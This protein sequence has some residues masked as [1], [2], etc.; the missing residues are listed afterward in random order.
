MEEGCAF[1][2]CFKKELNKCAKKPPKEAPGC[3]DHLHNW[4]RWLDE[5][6]KINQSLSRRLNCPKG[7]LLMN[8]IEEKRKIIEEK[9]LFVNERNYA[10]NDKYRGNPEWF[11]LPPR[12][13]QYCRNEPI[14]EIVRTQEEMREIV[15][16]V[17]IET[18]T[19]ILKEKDILPRTRNL[20]LRWQK[21]SYRQQVFQRI[22]KKMR[23]L[24]PH[25]PKLSELMVT[26]TSIGGNKEAKQGGCLPVCPKDSCTKRQECRVNTVVSKHE[27]HVTEVCHNCLEMTTAIHSIPM[28]GL[29]ING[30]AVTLASKK[31]S[32]KLIFLFQ[33]DVIPL[34]PME[35]LV[36]LENMGSTTLR[37]HF[38]KKKKFPIFGDIIPYRR[39]SS[40]FFFN[41]NEIILLPFQTIQLPIWFKTPKI[42]NFNETWNVS[43]LPEC[44]NHP[45]YFFLQGIVQI[46]EN[47]QKEQQ[48]KSMI[49]ARTR[50]T[51]VNEMIMNLI[52]DTKSEQQP[53]LTY[54][55]T[56]KDLF[57]SIN[58]EKWGVVTRPKY[59]YVKDVVNKLKELYE[60]VKKAD[61][62][63]V[64]DL[65][66]QTLKEIV[67]KRDVS[68]Y[69]ESLYKDCKKMKERAEY[70]KDLYDNPLTEFKI[71]KSS[72][73]MLQMS[74]HS[75]IDTIKSNE[76]LVAYENYQ[77]FTKLV[78]QLTRT[79]MIPNKDRQKYAMVYFIWRF[80]M[81]KIA[82][83]LGGYNRNF[84]DIVTSVNY[85]EIQDVENLPERLIFE[86]FD[87]IWTKRMRVERFKTD[88]SR[89]GNSDKRKPPCL[90]GISFDNVE[91]IHQTYMARRL[92][93]DT[94]KKK[95]NKD[96]AVTK[97]KLNLHKINSTPV[98]EYNP[99]IEIPMPPSP[100][101]KKP[102]PNESAGKVPN[103]SS[104]SSLHSTNK[105]Y[106]ERYLIVYT[107]LCMAV[108][109]MINSLET[110]A[111]KNIPIPTLGELASCK[112]VSIETVYKA[113]SG[114]K[115]SLT[116]KESDYYKY[117]TKTYMENPKT[118]EFF[119]KGKTLPVYEKLQEFFQ[120][121]TSLVSG[122]AS[123]EY[124]VGEVKQDDYA[125]VAVQTIDTREELDPI[126]NVLLRVESDEI[127]RD[128][129][130]ERMMHH[131]YGDADKDEE[132]FYIV[133]SNERTPEEESVQDDS[134]KSLW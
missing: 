90:D 106:Q 35:K 49:E 85:Y 102:E 113:Q 55:Y 89:I 105:D 67:R 111:E 88:F 2:S 133:D 37:I 33:S 119:V 3:K 31:E 12:L 27:P 121:N 94:K 79:M 5:R 43:T 54:Y 41:K 100:F 34:V 68:N 95:E 81:A 9:T 124:L 115:L 20:L 6:R 63:P 22:R 117:L 53:T 87:N 66:L 107:N 71:S 32:L 29:K 126:S 134:K 14:I 127:R 16:I 78:H 96:E 19:D 84:A 82:K 70:L 40:P 23:F 61:D 132:V 76:R 38:K 83:D 75:N 86:R 1:C 25:R 129:S 36:V 46:R 112:F 24:E 30:N 62:P 47:I 59:F 15:P 118:L 7:E 39:Q 110:M 58:M 13:Y 99:Y 101:L 73:K 57:E 97:S 4:E 48:I 45:I 60:T 74:T 51:L 72:S 130:D 56:E 114:S 131:D 44:C 116:R 123:Q 104:H 26:G 21:G 98:V 17:Y 108:D 122:W 92:S 93:T 103:N 109:A 28:I 10:Y 18:P 80:Y 64:W 42:G 50:Y 69:V 128:S 65:S 77:K 11:N 52:E 125:D 8:T 91:E 120:R